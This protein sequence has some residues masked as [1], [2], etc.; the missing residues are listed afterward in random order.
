MGRG[1][2]EAKGG[3]ADEVEQKLGALGAEVSLLTDSEFTHQ[4]TAG[5]QKEEGVEAELADEE[6]EILVR[7]SHAVTN[8]EAM[9]ESEFERYLVHLRSLRPAFRKFLEIKYKNHPYGGQTL[10]KHALRGSDDFREFLESHAYQ[11]YHKK[12]PRYIEQQPHR[13]AGLS[14]SHS[15]DVQTLHT[16]KPHIGRILGDPRAQP[17]DKHFVV[18][19]A[20]MTSRLL[21]GSKGEE[22]N[23]VTSLR[24]TGAVLEAAPE[25]VG[26]R[27]EGL[28]G[29]IVRTSVRVDSPTV[30]YKTA[31]P[32]PPGTR[33]YVGYLEKKQRDHSASMTSY[34][35]RK[36]VD[37]AMPE[38]QDM[39]SHKLLGA[40]Q[41]MISD[42]K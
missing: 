35:P 38:D 3:A 17:T 21:I 39:P 16:T 27:P 32:H 19:S 5:A 8:L 36:L 40:L 23:Q 41:S 26:A 18:A 34:A 25:V 31:N 29:A 4:E 9:S 33:E 11:E 14:Y 24:F 30:A 6:E 13:Y 28:E 10:F 22:V 37:F 42:T 15:P 1:W 2:G 20:G 7:R 12:R